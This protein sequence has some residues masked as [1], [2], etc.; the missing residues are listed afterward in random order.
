MKKIIKTPFANMYENAAFSS[1]LVTQGVMWEIAD[2]LETKGDWIK[3]RLPDGYEAW[4][5]NFSTLNLTP[6]FETMIKSLPRVIIHIPFLPIYA[7]PKMKG[8][9]NAV[10]ALAASFPY[11]KHEND[12]YEILMPNGQHGYIQ[13]AVLPVTSPRDIILYVADQLLGT[14]YF[15]GGKTENGCDCSGITQMCFSI[16][17]LSLPRDA[18]QQIK[19][20]KSNPVD[21]NKAKPGDLAFFQNEKGSITHVAIMR[22]ALEYIHSSGEVKLNSFN[23]NAAHYLKKLDNMLEGVYSIETIL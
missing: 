14:S 11:L 17:G 23:L 19:I 1:Q 9:R 7:N 15:W 2:V 6:E 3:L 10:A 4:S 20:L 13:Q 16:A 5:Q 21:V 12:V 18:S 8:C 22:K